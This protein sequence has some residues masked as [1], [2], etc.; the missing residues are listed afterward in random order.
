M[1]DLLKKIVL[2]LVVAAS[3]ALLVNRLSPHGI[4]LVGQWDTK[5]G[6]VTA[7]TATAAVWMDF[8]ISDPK[9]AKQVFDAGRA[10][11]VDVRSQDMFDEG[12]IPGAVFLPLGDFESRVEAF[13]AGVSP[14]QPIVTYCSGRLC[15]D[16][17]TAAQLLMERGFENVVVFIDGFPGWIENGYPVATP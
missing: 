10:L 7:D 3:L 9:V 1:Q 11:F 12:H 14:T 16:S 15:Q 2:L 8:E 13:A 4:P 5:L 17:H 6:V